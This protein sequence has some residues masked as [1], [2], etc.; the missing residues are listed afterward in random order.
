LDCRF[1]VLFRFFGSRFGVT[2]GFGFRFNPLLLSPLSA[3]L[4]SFALPLNSC[5][6]VGCFPR[7]LGF[8]FKR[9]ALC[10]SSGPPCGFFC[11]CLSFRCSGF[12]TLLLCPLCGLS[13]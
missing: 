6:P 12:L 8:A 9:Y 2:L 4:R 7:R 10:L 13:T 1:L 11:F 3:F 5:F